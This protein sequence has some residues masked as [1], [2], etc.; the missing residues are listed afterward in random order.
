M[1]L[2]AI[3]GDQAIGTATG[4]ITRATGQSTIKNIPIAVVGDEVTV[5][6][7]DPKTG[8]PITE[9]GQIIS[10]PAKTTIGGQLLVVDGAQWQSPSF[11]GTIKASLGS[12]NMAI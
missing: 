7:P 1:P 5:T 4:T 6:G 9:Q 2:I 12:P 3:Q 10:S 8:S 11:T